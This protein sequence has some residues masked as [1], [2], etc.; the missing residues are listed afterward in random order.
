MPACRDT[1]SSS[2]PLLMECSES[3][4]IKPP[5]LGPR[6]DSRLRERMVPGLRQI[7]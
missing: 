2:A 3:L 1:G 4:S 6:L 5:G 7:C